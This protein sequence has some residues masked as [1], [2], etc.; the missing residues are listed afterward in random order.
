M[1]S[2]QI[3]LRI[4]SEFVQ[5]YSAFCKSAQSFFD[6]QSTIF[7]VSYICSNDH[8]EFVTLIIKVINY[9]LVFFIRFFTITIYYKNRLIFN[10]ANYLRRDAK[11]RKHILISELANLYHGAHTISMLASSGFLV[12]F[13][14]F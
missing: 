6:L 3:I 11:I 4:I 9:E 12:E 10:P 13:V 2:K 1:T 5:K 8:C 7:L 14:M